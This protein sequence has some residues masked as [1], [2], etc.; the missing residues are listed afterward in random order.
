MR[1]KDRRWA[2]RRPAGC[3]SRAARGKQCTTRA[4]APRKERA[5][6]RGSE[7][8]RVARIQVGELAV[9]TLGFL[10]DLALVHQVL[11]STIGTT[12][13]Q[14]LIDAWLD[15]QAEGGPERHSG[16]GDKAAGGGGWRRRAAKIHWPQSRVGA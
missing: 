7:A 9:E 14:E 12:I 15:S 13:R 3:E 10:D 6:E 8:A 16:G 11:E 1:V 2:S 4:K 5:N